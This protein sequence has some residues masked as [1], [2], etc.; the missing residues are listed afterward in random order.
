MK[1][2]FWTQE[3]VKKLKKLSVNY[4]DQEIADIL[5]RPLSSIRAKRERIGIQKLNGAVPSRLTDVNKWD[6]INGKEL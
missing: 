2:K 4:S 1:Y 3:E 5:D 6:Y